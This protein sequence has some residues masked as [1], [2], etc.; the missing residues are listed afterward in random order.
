MSYILDALKKSEQQ[1]GNGTIPNVQTIH[2]SSLHYRDEKKA[3]WPYI[4]IAVVMLNLIAI[5]YFIIDKDNSSENNNTVSLDSIINSAKKTTTVDNTQTIVAE[6]ISIDKE[7][8][9]TTTNTNNKVQ[10][11]KTKTTLPIKTVA[12]QKTKP[13]NNHE[14]IT[15][16]TGN[17]KSENKLRAQPQKEIISYHDLPAATQ[18]QLPTIVVSAH[19]YSSNPLQR[20]MVINNNFKE[21]GEYV[22]DNLILHEITADGAI[23]DYAEIRFYYNVVSGWQ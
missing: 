5:V 17:N 11:E 23:F 12:I 16:D 10:L 2:S 20:S 1:R 15:P 18:Q 14:I 13:I 9:E 8:K 21:E 22:I 7:T 6:E 4:L 3:Y 19:V